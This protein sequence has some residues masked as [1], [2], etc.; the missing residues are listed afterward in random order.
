[1]RYWGM[2]Q[3]C[4]KCD[5]SAQVTFGLLGVCVQCGTHPHQ[6]ERDVYKKKAGDMAA[7]VMDTLSE[8]S[9][10]ASEEG[11]LWI[12]RSKAKISERID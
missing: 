12:A 3:K 8:V 5:Y 4:P 2:N 11:A 10:E 9:S 7:I 6:F 1:M